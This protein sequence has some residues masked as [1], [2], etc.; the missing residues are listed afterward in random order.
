VLIIADGK[1]IPKAL[2]QLG[3]DRQW[4]NQQLQHR[5]LSDLQEIYLAAVEAD[6]IFYLSPMNLEISGSSIHY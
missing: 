1:L 2:E 5:G 4:L 3:K 6:G